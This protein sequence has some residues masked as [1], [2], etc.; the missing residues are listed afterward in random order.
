MSLE[1][2]QKFILM[3]KNSGATVM[4]RMFEFIIVANCDSVNDV[5]IVPCTQSSAAFSTNNAYLF[6]FFLIIP[7]AVAIALYYKRKAI[8]KQKQLFSSLREKL[9]AQN[10]GTTEEPP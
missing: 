2:F 1:I 3:G 10:S 6:S 4:P 9:V 5:R 8:H 7:F